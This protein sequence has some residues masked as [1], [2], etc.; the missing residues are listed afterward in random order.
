MP[1]RRV[2]DKLLQN[3]H[4]KLMPEEA[5]PFLQ[6]RLGCLFR[7][8][9]SAEWDPRLENH[10]FRMSHRLYELWSVKATGDAEVRSPVARGVDTS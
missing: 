3:E 4:I 9:G 10:P 6:S 5:V 8:C 1:L 7:Q 2:P